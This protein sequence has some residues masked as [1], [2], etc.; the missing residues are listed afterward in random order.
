[1][2]DINPPPRSLGSLLD[3]IGR[4]CSSTARFVLRTLQRLS[5]PAILLGCV[6]LALIVTV[7]PLAIMLFVI[8]L[9]IKLF[10]GQCSASAAARRDT[11]P[12]Q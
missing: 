11:T 10:T 8:F 1:M 12:Q 5:W 2:K 6:L 4:A 7:L 9:L 3:E